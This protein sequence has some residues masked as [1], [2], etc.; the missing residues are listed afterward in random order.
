MGTSY[1][2]LMNMQA[3]LIRLWAL[4]EIVA[5]APRNAQRERLWISD[6]DGEVVQSGN[7]PARFIPQCLATCTVIAFNMKFQLD[8]DLFFFCQSVD[9][10][11]NNVVVHTLLFYYFWGEEGC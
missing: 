3:A 6:L 9:L 5:A 8:S 2:L 7:T 4:G 11:A 10:D 1:L